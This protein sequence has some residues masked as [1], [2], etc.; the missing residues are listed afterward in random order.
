[1]P[2]HHPILSCGKD[3]YLLHGGHWALE[4]ALFEVVDVEEVEALEQRTEG[5]F[6]VVLICHSFSEMEQCRVRRIVERRWPHAATPD[7][8]RHWISCACT[9]CRRAREAMDRSQGLMTKVTQ[10]VERSGA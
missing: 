3:T 10:R 8:R 7:L 4:Y 2:I 6:D 9:Q 5:D 1:V